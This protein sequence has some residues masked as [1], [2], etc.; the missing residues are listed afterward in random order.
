[1]NA[2]TSDTPDNSDYNQVANI[3]NTK[4]TVEKPTYDPQ[5]LVTLIREQQK[6][7]FCQTTTAQIGHANSTFSYNSVRLLVRRSTVDGAIQIVVS[8]SLGQRILR[9]SYYPPIAGYPDQ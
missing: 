6:E 5:T 9:V 8:Q 2:N 7:V 3:N 1:M 4:A